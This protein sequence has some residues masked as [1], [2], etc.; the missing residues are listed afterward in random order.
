VSLIVLNTIDKTVLLQYSSTSNFPMA[1]RRLLVSSIA[2]VGSFAAAQFPPAPQD[3][4]T[5]EISSHLG[6]SIS[7]KETCICE[8]KAKAWAGYVHMPVSYLRDIEAI[9]PYNV[10]MFFW[11]IEA[12]DDP[13][14]APTA[15]YLAGGPGQ[16]SLW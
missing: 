8:T 6:V 7:Y 5:K 2:L 14:N 16:S 4:T 15:I 3:I 10:S 1:L 11:Y 13:Q 9:D 12:R